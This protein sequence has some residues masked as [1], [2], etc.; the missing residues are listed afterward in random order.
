[1]F[2][3]LADQLYAADCKE[4]WLLP[5]VRHTYSRIV[6]EVIAE[7]ILHGHLQDLQ[8]FMMDI[9]K[10]DLVLPGGWGCYPVLLAAATI[11]Q[12]NILVYGSRDVAGTPPLTI[13]PLTGAGRAAAAQQTSLRLCHWFET[14]F[15]SLADRPPSLAIT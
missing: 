13:Q 6:R 15:G 3:A 14:H 11:Y 5:Y 2:D 4:R 1:M 8:A 10:K 9:E 12:R 7:G